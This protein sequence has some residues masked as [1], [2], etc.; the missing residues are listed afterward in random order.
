MIH[1]VWLHSKITAPRATLEVVGRPRL[2]HSLQYHNLRKL[3]IVRAP[4]GYGKTTLLSQS[5]NQFDGWVA[6]LSIDA[7]DND[8]LRFWTYVIRAV[9]NEV[10]KNMDSLEYPEFNVLSPLE[11]LIDSFLNEIA[12]IPREILIVID[13]YHLIESPVIHKMMARFIDYLP[14]NTYL[15]LV[16]RTE[17]PLPLA[18]WRVQES[19]TEVGVD[20]LRFTYE[21]TEHLYRKRGFSYEDADSLEHV[22]QMTEG[23]A[24]GIQLVGLS[25]AISAAD[26]WDATQFDSKYPF[27]KEFLLQEILASLSP[28]VQD[29][30][31]RTS[32]LKQL[33][34]AI[35]DA[36]TNRTDSYSVLLE[37]ERKGLFIVR[38]HSSEP[39]FRYH[40]L[41]EDALRIEMRLRYS[42]KTIALFY[43]E[44]AMILIEQG[45]FISAIE[46]TLRGQLWDVSDKWMTTYLV[47]IFTLGQTG[48][49]IRWVRV[50]R[51]N[52]YVVNI[53]TL[54][55][56]VI[57]LSNI[58]EVEKAKRLIDELEKRDEV[59]NWM[60]TD[61]YRGMASIFATAKAFVLFAS[62]GDIEQAKELVSTQLITGRVSSR[63]DHI[64]MQYNQ[65]EARTLRTTIGVRGKLWSR[66]VVLPFLD[67]FRKTEFKEQNMTGFGY[68][69]QAETLYEHDFIDEALIELEAALQYGHRFQ[70]AGLYIPMYILKS[71]I[72]AMKKQFVEAH[73]TL[74]HAMKTMKERHWT[75][76]IR[77][78]KAHCYLLEGNIPQAEWELSKS[79][80]LNHLEAKS[81]QEFWLLVHIRLLLAKG[82]VEEALKTTIRIKEK[83]LQERQ[84]LTI[85]EAGILEAICQMRLSNEDAALS[86]LHGALKQGELYKYKRTFLDEVS[87]Q[88]LLERYL[89]VHR[90]GV[91][92]HWDSIPID[93]IEQLIEKNGPGQVID[94]LRPRER[95][96]LR[97]L[98][99]GASNSEIASQLGLSEG[100]VRVYLSTIYSKL[101]VNSR[102]KA[103]L[104]ATE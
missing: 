64:P 69:V 73:R 23:W 47:E 59:E 94:T 71:R 11:L 8:P 28:S 15:F 89:K 68:G 96:I 7:N 93:Y 49:F 65:L 31:V 83:A 35:C 97:L 42:P 50:L 62:G 57:A 29:F 63:W 6:W 67:L 18:K 13:D 19:L 61:E 102:T 98:A 14:D 12:M 10:A 70:D 72:Y 86:A 5:I 48:T 85:I 66:D 52:N 36:L 3:T 30:L 60:D 40:H 45:D 27:I 46:L 88:P 78:M 33:E 92:G 24:A 54:V 1:I 32:I 87:L 104:I 4:A 39:V 77:A 103:I 74:D 75:D 101:G 90:K 41:F 91:H 51:A 56:Y 37:L 79:T 21:E 84:T 34:P 44:V 43:E 76:L 99:E 81:E 2:V 82:Q 38:L 9:S 20:Q 80:G 22:L 17:L 95:E 25:G 16:S 58:Y 100:T 55:M 26:K 53:E